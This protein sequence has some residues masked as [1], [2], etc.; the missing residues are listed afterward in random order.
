MTEAR[1]VKL[2]RY[3]VKSMAGEPLTA[4]DVGLGG[5][6]GDR[7]W[8]VVDRGS[9]KVL[10][11]KAEPRL[12]E[13]TARLAGGS[14]VVVNLPGLGELSGDD[15]GIHDLLTAWLDREVQLERP[16]PGRRATIAGEDDFQAPA[17]SFFDSSS[18]LHLVTE[19]SLAA[20]AGLHPAGDWDIRRFR[21]NLLLAVDGQGYVEEDWIGGDL[22]L[23]AAVAR[24]RKPTGRCVLITRPQPGLPQDKQLLRVLATQRSNNFGVYADP[25][26]AG[27]IALGDSISAPTKRFRASRARSAPASQG[28]R[29]DA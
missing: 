12:L 28:A 21:P 23:G 9:G 20:A 27:R 13:G 10:S 25:V 24:V 8:A 6:P 19:A 22:Q 1:V 5:I 2:W 26:R 14:D 11:A 17:G 18:A 7:A 16:V 15:P 4:A 29:S 3:P